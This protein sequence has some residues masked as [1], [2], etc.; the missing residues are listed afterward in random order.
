MP[1]SSFRLDVRASAGVSVS[2]WYM[3]RSL[4]MKT[5]LWVILT[6]SIETY[7]EIGMRY[8]EGRRAGVGKGHQDEV[9]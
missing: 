3:C 2:A 7:R 9:P 6:I 5:M 4:E 1:K 8:P